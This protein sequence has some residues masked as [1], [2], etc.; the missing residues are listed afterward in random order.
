MKVGMVSLGCSKN[1]VDSEKIM[2]MLLAGGHE[3][4]NQPQEAEAIIINTCGFIASAKEEA[5]DTIF[6]MAAYKQQHLQKLIVVGCLAQRYQ[7]QLEEEIPEIDAV[8]RISEYPH[9]HERLGELLGGNPMPAFAQSKRRLASRPWTAYL[10]IAEG[11]SNCCT[12]CAIPM[13]RGA[14]VSVPME[15]LVQEAQ[16]LADQGVKELVLIAQD[17]TKYGL[18]LYGK[19]SLLALLQAVHEIDGFHWIRILYM[20]PDEI[21]EELVAGMAKLPK[22]VPYF[23]IPLQHANDDILKRM[24]RRGTVADVRRL[25]AMIRSYYP[26]PILRTTFIVGFPQESEQEFAELLQFVNDIK[27][28]RMGAF[29][30]SPEEDTPAYAMPGAIAASVKQE[31]LD[32]LMQLQEQISLAKQQEMVGKVIE[33]LVEGQDG[34]SGI[35]RGRSQSSAPDEVDGLVFFHSAK[36]LELGSFVQVEVREALPY[37]LKGEAV[38]AA[39]V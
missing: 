4:V 16:T 15:K 27:W 21:D 20:Y 28:D 10:K 9:L 3:L 24:N 1:L 33:V 13:I 18:D 36:P 38:V 14:N 8:I 2:G 29:I 17:T 11:C 30:Y 35:Y 23:D 12:Y 22:V 5:I 6:E 32:R 31:R 25:V 26:H 34:L 19:T 39:R 37:D 7:K